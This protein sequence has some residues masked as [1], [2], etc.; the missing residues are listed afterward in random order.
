M[1]KP[2]LQ[3]TILN[4]NYTQVRH[5]LKTEHMY[6]ILIWTKITEINSYYDLSNRIKFCHKNTGRNKNHM[7]VGFT[8]T[9][10]YIVFIHRKLL[11][12]KK[13]RRNSIIFILLALQCLQRIHREIWIVIH[14]IW[15]E[16]EALC[17]HNMLYFYYRWRN[18]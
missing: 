8:D 14:L 5:S 13:S 9:S 3:T 16:T 12:L 4:N 10:K 6:S 18:I 17:N 2:N 11:S 7:C 1:Y 15:C